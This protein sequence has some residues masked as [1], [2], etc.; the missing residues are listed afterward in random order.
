[1]ANDVKNL[2]GGD[3]GTANNG[4]SVVLAARTS[5]AAGVAGKVQTIDSSG[6]NAFT[7]AGFGTAPPGPD[8]DVRFL[9]IR[10]YTGDADA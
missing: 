3:T 4:R 9:A 10:F 7:I 1:M 2:A 8:L 5:V 6:F